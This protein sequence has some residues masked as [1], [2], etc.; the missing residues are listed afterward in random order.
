MIKSQSEHDF[1]FEL[2]RNGLIDGTKYE[3]SERKGN[4]F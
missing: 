3:S 2:M 1:P 4:L